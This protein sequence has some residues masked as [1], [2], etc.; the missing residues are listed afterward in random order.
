MPGDFAIVSFRDA[1][2]VEWRRR[3]D[4]LEL[5]RPAWHSR[6]NLVRKFVEAADRAVPEKVSVI[7]N[8]W[9]YRRA[10]KAAQSSACP[11][12]IIRFARFGLMG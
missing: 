10:F 11:I 8:G 2:G 1:R 7:V 9:F 12:G 6:L 3:S 4:T 5:D